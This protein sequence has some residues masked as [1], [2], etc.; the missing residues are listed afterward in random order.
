MILPQIQYFDFLYE[1][2]K[3]YSKCKGVIIVFYILCLMNLLTLGLRIFKNAWLSFVKDR[4][5]F[6]FYTRIL[7]M[8]TLLTLGSISAFILSNYLIVIY[9]L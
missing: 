9:F 4:Y 8:D 1:W 2:P 6:L 7:N 3:Q 5:L